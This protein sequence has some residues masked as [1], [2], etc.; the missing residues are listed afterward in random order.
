MAKLNRTSDT[1]NFS[2][3]RVAIV[4]ANLLAF[5]VVLY[6]WVLWRVDND[7][8]IRSVQEDQGLEWAS[9]LAFAAAAVLFAVAA[10]R[11]RRALGVVPWYLAGLSVFCL[12]V[13]LEE[14]SWAQR[15]F[16]YRP[17]TYFL[18]NNFQQE[19][20]FHNVVDNDLRQLTVKAFLLC[21]GVLFPLVALHRPLRR[22]LS[23]WSVV[24]PPIGL[25]PL[26][27]VAFVLYVDYPWR[28]TGEWVELVMGLG[29]LFAALAPFYSWRTGRDPSPRRQRTVVAVA[30]LA[31]AL[32]GEVLAVTNEQLRG[33]QPELVEAARREAEALSADFA[34]LDDPC[35]SAR[36]LDQRVYTYF[37]ETGEPTLL[38]GGFAA[39][40]AQGL[41]DDR[42]RYFLDP[43]NSPYWVKCVREGDR[44]FRYV[45][46][47][48]ANRRRE[49]T[50]WE[51]LG[52]D[53]G[54]VFLSTGG[55]GD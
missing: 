27:L 1:L 41:S 24:A 11:Q 46:S 25:A 53:V 4:I 29:L 9:F 34:A 7:F 31:V 40:V 30:F 8:Y 38:S 15:I 26:F 36:R 28:F 22:F 21:F 10:V 52:D 55:P 2:L 14:I 54:A 39:L 43:W 3:E 23:G 42:A 17:P 20:N 45:Y 37:D 51:V 19:L 35:R 5:G 33:E 32:G 18:E 49:S 6:A 12:F 16:A 13:A 47:F 48:G 44:E 50:D